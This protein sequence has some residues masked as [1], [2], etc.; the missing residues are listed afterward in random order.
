LGV[1]KQ[2]RGLR[3]QIRGGGLEGGASEG[4]ERIERGREKRETTIL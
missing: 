1:R 4:V 2:R 3:G